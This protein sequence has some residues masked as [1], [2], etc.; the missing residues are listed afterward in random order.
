MLNTFIS[1]LLLAALTLSMIPPIPARAQAGSAMDLIQSVNAYRA[2][3]GLA[4]YD[5]DGGLMSLAQSHSE[6]Q[7][8]IEECTHSRVDGSSP[9]DHGISAENIA[10]GSNL[11]V[12]DAIYGQW[13]D[14][15]HAATIL[16]PT[17]GLVGAGTA[18][19]GS[20]VY[21]TLAV[22][23]LSG[24]FTYIP[25]ANNTNNTD[26][27]T[28]VDPAAQSPA[29]DPPGDPNATSTPNEDGS[30]AHVIK[31]GETLVD[32]AN[33]YGM[34]LGDLIAI[35]KLDPANPVYYENQVLIIRVA[36][37]L[38]P[39]Y[40]ATYTPRPPTRTPMPSR[41]PRPTR[42]S[43]PESTPLPTRTATREPVVQ[44][45]S[46]EDLGPAR[47]LLAYTFIAISALGLLVL[48]Y[49]SFGPGRKD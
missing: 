18:S 28:N 33:R 26:P 22:R 37:T 13:A 6:Y 36:F 15:L 25:P 30:I 32:I 4:P 42:T 39:Y 49:T 17:T 12:S 7:A 34:S 23:R 47:P 3:Q 24:D 27:S 14:Q 40:T 35:N 45:P 31:Y 43:G 1:A 9:G 19:A 46:L 11:S 8:S 16:G 44:L 10:C 41:T 29:Q 48:L 21:Y 38:T 20:M 2:Q 5:V